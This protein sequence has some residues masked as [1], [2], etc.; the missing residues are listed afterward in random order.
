MRE[1]TCMQTLVKI[2][3]RSRRDLRCDC[4]GAMGRESRRDRA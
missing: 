1:K 2:L 4:R 3:P